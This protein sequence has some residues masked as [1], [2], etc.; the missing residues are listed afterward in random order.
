MKLNEEQQRFVNAIEDKIILMSAA[1]SG[2]TRSIVE[3]T[4]KLVNDG[5]SANKIVV[6]TFTNMA[7]EELRQR[8][9]GYPVQIY[10]IHGY[11]N[12]LLRA[13]GHDTS[14]LINDEK[15]DRLFLMIKKFPECAKEVDYLLLDEGHDTDA[16]QFEFI[17]DIVKPKKWCICADL[18]QTIYEWRGAHPDYILKLLNQKDV[19]VYNLSFNYRCRKNILNFAKKI[20]GKLGYDFEDH[21]IPVQTGG[22]VWE[23]DYDL[24]YLAR[25]IQRDGIYKDWFILTRSNKEIEDMGEYLDK[26]SIP[27]TTFKQGDINLEQLKEELEKDQLVLLTIHSAKGL[28]RSKVAVVGAV[29]W[30][31]DETIRVNYVAATR[32][33][34]W[35]VWLKPKAKK[36][37]TY[38]PSWRDNFNNSNWE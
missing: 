27:F 38:K 1:G 34:D 14:H 12:Y 32:A 36:R 33:K 9:D 35:L 23:I 24:D 31:G 37:K 2:K 7:T 10:T 26:Y 19:T 6:L 25:L 17:F 15:F 22:E 18:K 21:S 11:C 20:I 29:F 5:L 30:G 13:G 16:N 8:L 28:E 4:K 3:K